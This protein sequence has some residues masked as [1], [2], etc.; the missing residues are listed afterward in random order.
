MP[1]DITTDL[2]PDSSTDRSALVPR[3]RARVTN[4]RDALPGLDGRSA[5]ARR[6]RDFINSFITD[7]GGLDAIS[8]IKL[9]LLRRLAATTIQAELVEARM[10]NGEQIDVAVLCTLA[11]V[12]VRLSQRLGLE[13]VARPIPDL[14]QS[15][16]DACQ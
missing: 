16:G 11:S 12:T 8:E 3:L 6:Y 15:E 14:L 4:H 2:V 13:R 9:G 5:S 7:L 1:H 10:V